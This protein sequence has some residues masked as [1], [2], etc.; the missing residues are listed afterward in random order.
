[1]PDPLL[2]AVLLDH[3]R[4]RCWPMSLPPSL[5]CYHASYYLHLLVLCSD[6]CS[7]PSRGSSNSKGPGFS[8][9]RLAEKLGGNRWGRAAQRGCCRGT[10]PHCH[11]LRL[12]SSRQIRSAWAMPAE[13][14]TMADGLLK[15]Q[16]L[17]LVAGCDGQQLVAAA[18]VSV[19]AAKNIMTTAYT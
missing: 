11:N 17:I 4:G 18:E 3:K 7:G 16:S 5:S 12:R 19:A 13:M 2:A 6:S 8:V 1:M 10:G 9:G 15:S 14:T